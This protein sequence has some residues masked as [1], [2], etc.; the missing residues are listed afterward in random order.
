MLGNPGLDRDINP[1]LAPSIGHS[2]AHVS[3]VHQHELPLAFPRRMSDRRSSE[4]SAISM[5]PWIDENIGRTN[6]I[7]LAVTAAISFL[8]VAILSTR[9]KRETLAAWFTLPLALAPF[10]VGVWFAVRIGLLF[11]TAIGAWA[12]PPGANQNAQPELFTGQPTI[13]LAIGPLLG[14]L[15]SCPSFVLAFIL[16]IKRARVAHANCPD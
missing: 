5:L 4:K 16:S 6:L 1:S 12:N 2:L 7:T 14:I 3:I 8:L 9:V 10:F 15:F 13:L 11:L